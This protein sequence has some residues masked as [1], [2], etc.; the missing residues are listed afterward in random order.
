MKPILSQ[1]MDVNSPNVKLFGNVMLFNENGH[2]RA[3]APPHINSLHK[4]AVSTLE[5]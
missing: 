3:F 5:L 4:E 1:F 2:F